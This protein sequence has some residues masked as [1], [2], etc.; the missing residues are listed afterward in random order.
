MITFIKVYSGRLMY[1]YAKINQNGDKR[2]YDDMNIIRYSLIFIIW[3]IQKVMVP[4]F[5]SKFLTWQAYSYDIVG[6]HIRVTH[7]T[8]KII[9]ELV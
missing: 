1:D 4:R 7:F 5:D 2:H 6:S 8:C 3:F 9:R